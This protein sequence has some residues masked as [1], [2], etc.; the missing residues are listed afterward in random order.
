MSSIETRYSELTEHIRE[1]CDKYNRPPA[2]LLAVSKTKPLADIQALYSA[3]QRSFGENYLQEAVEKKNHLLSAGSADDI[4]WHFIGPLQ[5]NKTKLAAEN[6]C[7]VQTVD[8]LKI[9]RRLSE[10]RP[11]QMPP[12]NVLVQVNISGEESKSGVPSAEV[13]A[14]LGQIAELPRLRLRG[15]MAIPA[16]AEGLEAQRQ[17]LRAMRLL[18]EQHAQTYDFDTLSMGMS[19][20]MEAAIAEGSTKLRVGT[21]LFGERK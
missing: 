16:P 13:P 12:L 8:R 9:A 19:S 10:Q 5:S 17:P 20:D 7:W 6:M 14:L 4:Q 3:G 21:A 18:Y 15:L 11:G 1:L 2:Q